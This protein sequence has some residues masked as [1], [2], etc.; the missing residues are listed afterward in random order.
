MAQ[1]EIT[2]LCVTFEVADVNV[3]LH[4]KFQSLK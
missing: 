3:S 2:V 4:R 1:A